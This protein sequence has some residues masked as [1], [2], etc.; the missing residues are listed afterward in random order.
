MRPLQ[1]HAAAPWKAACRD[2][3]HAARLPLAP[4]HLGRAVL[5]IARHLA[6]AP[7]D[8]LVKSLGRVAAVALWCM[9]AGCGG[10]V[11][12]AQLQLE[13]AARAVW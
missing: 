12:G 11:F 8:D 5:A 13:H 3:C 2:A 1:A 7:V 9:R 4:G 10:A 6:L